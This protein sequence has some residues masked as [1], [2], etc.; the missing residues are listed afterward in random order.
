[1]AQASTKPRLRLAASA[2]WLLA[3]AAVVLVAA[4]TSDRWLP[5]LRERVDRAFLAKDDSK[6]DSHDDAKE[7]G[8]AGHDHGHPGH[9]ENTAIE[10]SEQARKN[11]GLKIGK[12][13]LQ[14]FTRN[15]LVP[16]IVVERPG[17]ST[18]Q[19]TAPMAGI[20]TRIY[21][22][23]GEAVTPGHKL[24]DIRLTD[25]DLVQSQAD[26]LRT[27]EELDVVAREIERIE[28]LTTEGGL[29]G[30]T[31]LERKYEQQKQQAVIRS[32]RQALTLHGLTPAQ[33]EDILQTRKLVQFLSINAPGPTDGMSTSGEQRFYQVRDLRIAQGQH[34]NAGDALAELVDHSEL[35]IEGNAFE[36]DVAAVNRASTS[37]KS[38]SALLEVEAGSPQT[39]SD[40]KILFTAPQIEAESRTLHFYVTLPN[41]IEQNRQLE[42][43]RRYI[44]WRFRPGQRT[45]LQIPVDLWKDR[46]VL[47]VDAI[48]EEGAEAYVFI[49]NGDHFDRR[50]VHIEYKDSSAVVIANDGVLFRGDLVVLSAAKQL[51]LA[52]KNKSGG[53]PDPHAGHN[54]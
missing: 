52:L 13:E 17:R 39:I 20:I 25:E 27:A 35:F 30:K 14:P 19:V 47:P 34:V 21:P 15:L 53:G 43:G 29:A 4:F 3:I 16:G 12:I 11:I 33:V 54:H 45:Q 37:E 50:A 1:M 18:V 10:L 5:Q 23:E 36:R 8:H 28:K 24:F 6:E 32:Q 46:I 48:V 44:A 9:A 49:P 26:L 51:Q 38:V 31:L 42:D 40:L 22:T 2:W 41:E 7:S